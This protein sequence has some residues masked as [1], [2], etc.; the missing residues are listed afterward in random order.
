MDD[1]LR[2]C[3]VSRPGI[4]LR[5]TAL[6]RLQQLLLRALRVERALHEGR[7][8][9]V[10][11]EAG[12][13]DVLRLRLRL[14]QQQQALRPEARAVR[15]R[16]LHGLR[17]EVCGLR[18]VRV[19]RVLHE[20]DAVHVLREVLEQQPVFLRELYALHAAHGQHALHV[21]RVLREVCVLHRD[22]RCGCGFAGGR[23][24]ALRC[25]Q[26]A[27]GLPASQPRSEQQALPWRRT[28][29]PAT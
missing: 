1:R 21:V 7:E 2:R 12:G 11:H 19:E 23:C 15:V 8:A 4:A 17:H 29:L 24:D 6:L 27:Q 5:W 28:G 20:V 13:P 25:V 14:R 18:E 9:G 26:V 16:A 22:D 10:L 3:P